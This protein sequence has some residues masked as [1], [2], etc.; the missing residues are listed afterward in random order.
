MTTCFLV[1]FIGVVLLARR[2]ARCGGSLRCSD[3][4]GL[5]PRAGVRENSL[6]IPNYQFPI[7]NYQLPIT[8]SPTEF[9][10]HMLQMVV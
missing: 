1:L 5:Q 2:A 3:C 4:G 10:Y 8:N 7:P 6:P 9:L